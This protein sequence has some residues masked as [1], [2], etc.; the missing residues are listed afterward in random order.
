LA[1]T[2]GELLAQIIKMNSQIALPEITKFKN[3]LLWETDRL[4]CS[5]DYILMELDCH[6]Q[7]CI[8]FCEENTFCEHQ[9]A[10]HWVDQTT[11]PIYITS[12]I[13][14]HFKITCTP[15]WIWFERSYEV[16]RYEGVL[17][18]QEAVDITKHVFG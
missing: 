14:D 17:E 12:E 13:V 2:K 6:D 15:T 1:N 5:L 11:V 8:L 18:Q 16:F 10:N 4:N 9:L 7:F 3:S